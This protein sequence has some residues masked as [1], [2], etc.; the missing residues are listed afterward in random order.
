MLCSFKTTIKKK[1]VSEVTSLSWDK[2]KCRARDHSRN[3]KRKPGNNLVWEGLWVHLHLTRE[4]GSKC[5][6]EGGGRSRQ[7][8][9]RPKCTWSK[10]ISSSPCFQNDFCERHPIRSRPCPRLPS[11]ISGGKVVP[12]ERYRLPFHLQFHPFRVSMPATSS[13]S[14]VSAVTQIARFWPLSVLLRNGRCHQN[15]SVTRFP[16]SSPLYCACAFCLPTSTQTI[17]HLHLPSIQGA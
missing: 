6:V 12:W 15:Q 2:V 17:R 5:T 10:M 16:L 8:P 9:R 7:A 11:P 3:I 1:T 4:E 13:K 14:Q